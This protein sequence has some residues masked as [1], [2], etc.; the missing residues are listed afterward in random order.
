MSPTG[1]RGW[2]HDPHRDPAGVICWCRAAD[3]S[4]RPRSELS[5]GRRLR[6]SNV[7]PTDNVLTDPRCL[8]AQ[9]SSPGVISSSP[10]TMPASELR[11]Q[12]YADRLRGRLF[13]PARRT[14]PSWTWRSTA[15]SR[16][17]LSDARWASPPPCQRALHTRR[18][19]GDS[20]RAWPQMALECTGARDEEAWRRSK[21]EGDHLFTA[22]V[23][24]RRGFLRRDTRR[25]GADGRAML[26]PR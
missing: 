2:G 23:R 15:R 25:R 7:Q 22:D 4:E 8:W 17:I 18:S 19:A 9:R 13:R 14:I 1:G 26:P 11:G 16:S 3:G 24:E 5:T 10:P 21:A 12:A 20:T 6:R